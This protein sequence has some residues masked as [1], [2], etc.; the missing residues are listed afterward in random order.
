MQLLIVIV[1]YVL[2]SS[3]VQAKIVSYQ[4][5]INY[6]TLQFAGKQAK[7][8]AINGSVPA[9]TL[10]FQEG[11]KAEITVTNHMDVDTSIHWHG[12]L[13]PNHEDGVPYV[14]HP[15]IKPGT[16]H[17]FRFNIRQSGTYWYHSHTGLQE[18]QGMYGAIVI[19]PR[20]QR[21]LHFDQQATVVLS[22]WTQEHPDEVLRSL[23]G[24]SEYYS[25]KKNSRQNLQDAITNEGVGVLLKQAWSRMPGMDISDVAYDQ[26]LANGQPQTFIP[27][28]P[29]E[30]IK[31]RLVNAATASYFNLQFAQGDFKI[32]ATDGIDV[33]PIS[34]NT[35]LMA[36][37]ETYTLLLKVPE[38][39]MYE[40]RATAQDGSGYSSIWIGQGKKVSAPDRGKPNPYKAHDHAGRP[41]D[42]Q[43]SNA[44]PMHYHGHHAHTEVHDVSSN[45]A[46]TTPYADLRAIHSTLLPQKNITR[47]IH[48]DLT[49][50]MERYVWSIN[51]EI[52]SAD[53]VI[54]I[55]RG[56]NIRFVM[57]NKTMMHHPMHLHG[58]FFRLLNGQGDYSPL[59]HT[60]DVPPMGQ[61]IIEF[62][63]NE[64]A[65]WFFHCHILY[66][67]RSGM[68]RVISYQD[69]I[70]KELE[71]SRHLLYQEPWY[72]TANAHV[73]SQMTEGEVRY[74]NSKN[75]FQADWE[76]GW[77]NVDTTEYE[78]NVIYQ[79]YFNRYFSGFAGITF[80]HG[81]ERGIF[82]GNYL[83]P[84]SFESE[85]RVDTEGE[86]RIT[87]EQEIQLTNAVNAYA[88]FQYDTESEEEWQTGVNYRI[89]KY[90]GIISGYHSEF[91]WG[92]GVSFTY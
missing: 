65:D 73:L 30:T 45:Q 8:M 5:S 6:K 25:I 66:H 59:K 62:E 63:A 22:D 75:S 86:F 90:L 71:E 29:G 42:M 60:V 53:N 36:V 13:L 2:G 82:G 68:A 47:E 44:N 72:L 55:R 88:E 35:F 91:G 69:D 32:I 1:L 77:Q 50:D 9:P 56:E 14:N 48:L 18:Q 84:L 11:D 33:E 40:L 10:Y 37:A 21:K 4:L 57:N 74:S 79:R 41:Q 58:H 31:L 7:G 3:V 87:I 19:E 61:R 54:K 52:L 85:W 89:H 78:V 28:R 67:A 16:S 51:N 27:A 26:F 38:Q 39:G 24:G 81:D 83:L 70:G 92:G 76:V 34:T 17:T 46:V 80:E 43:K 20:K 12:I 64:E 15:P 49:G 23:K